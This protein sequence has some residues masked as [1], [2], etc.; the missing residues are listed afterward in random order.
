M[1]GSYKKKE[2]G[3]KEMERKDNKTNK[4]K[5]QIFHSRPT[6]KINKNDQQSQ[7]LGSF[8]KVLVKNM[9]LIQNI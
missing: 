2:G 3:K 8:A 9:F 5:P 4:T 6:K 7:Q 1:K